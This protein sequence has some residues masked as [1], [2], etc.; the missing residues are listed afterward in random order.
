LSSS[1]SKIDNNSSE[2]YDP[3]DDPI[4]ESLEVASAYFASLGVPR[5]LC[6]VAFAHEPGV[7]ARVVFFFDIALL[8]GTLLCSLFRQFYLAAFLPARLASFFRNCCGGAR[9]NP[10]GEVQLLALRARRAYD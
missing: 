1:S 7:T 3:L 5:G 10:R 6:G 8:P 9:I 2:F 4:Y